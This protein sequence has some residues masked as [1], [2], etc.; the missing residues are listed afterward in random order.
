MRGASKLYSFETVVIC[1][2]GGGREVGGCGQR[3]S[4]LELHFR[5]LK[6]EIRWKKRAA[7]GLVQAG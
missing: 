1:T 4:V 7:D 2:R 5:E 3:D 6:G